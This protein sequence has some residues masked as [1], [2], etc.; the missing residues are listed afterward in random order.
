[1][2]FV[3]FRFVYNDDA[4]TT[5]KQEIEDPPCNQVEK[6]KIESEK[7]LSPPQYEQQQKIRPSDVRQASIREEKQTP[8]PPPS[9]KEIKIA[10]E[11]L[12][13]YGPRLKQNYMIWRFFICVF[14]FY[15]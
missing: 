14:I 8:R 4:V 7:I 15:I 5:V 10:S 9:D 6:T 1:M 12:C 3:L 13:D 11:Y 2:L